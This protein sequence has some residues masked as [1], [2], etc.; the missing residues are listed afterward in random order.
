MR[1]TALL[2]GA[3]A[4]LA[5]IS[6]LAIS[7]GA[8]LPSRVMLEN[9]KVKVTEVT[10]EPGVP[11]ERYLRPSDQIIVFLDNCRYRRTD[12]ASGEKTVRERKS[13]DVIWHNKGE[14]A[15]VLENL[16]ARP[17]RTLVIELK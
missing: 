12:S 9:D 7:R 2:C 4:V 3:S 17:Y 10:Y 5:S 13:G 16:E 15:P 1:N 11:R 6:T 14:D 8:S